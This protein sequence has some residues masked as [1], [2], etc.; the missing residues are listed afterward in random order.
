MSEREEDQE[1]L[2]LLDGL[3]KSLRR[4]ALRAAARSPETLFE[5]LGYLELVLELK[6][7]LGR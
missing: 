7:R 2:K 5:E 6:N 3:D 4:R 1:L